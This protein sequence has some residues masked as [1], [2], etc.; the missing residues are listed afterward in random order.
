MDKCKNIKFG[1][2]ANYQI[3]VNGKLDSSLSER[4]GGM[5]IESKVISEVQVIT[6]LT[7]LLR[8]QA[9]LSG[10]LNSLYEMHFPVISVKCLGAETTKN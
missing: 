2:K 5:I 6:T 4:L 1:G 8:D 10:L 9:A 3:V 7:G